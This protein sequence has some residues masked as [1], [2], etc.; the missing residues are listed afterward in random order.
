MDLLE[1]KPSSICKSHWGEFGNNKFEVLE[2]SLIS[3]LKPMNYV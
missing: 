1:K 3:Y 2:Q